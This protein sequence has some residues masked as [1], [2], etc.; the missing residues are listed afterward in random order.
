[1]YED[2]DFV[3]QVISALSFGGFVHFFLCVSSCHFW[4]LTKLHLPEGKSLLLP[5]LISELDIFTYGF[6]FQMP[7][8]F[9]AVIPSSNSLVPG[10]DAG[11][12]C[13]VLA[14][15]SKWQ[16]YKSL[17]YRLPELFSLLSLMRIPSTVNFGSSWHCQLDPS[18]PCQQQVSVH[19]S[20]LNAV[21]GNSFAVSQFNHLGIGLIFVPSAVLSFSDS[22]VKF[23]FPSK[24]SF[25][26][27][28]CDQSKPSVQLRKM[29]FTKASVWWMTI[30]TAL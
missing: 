14:W 8:H 20:F 23:N 29:L 13:S 5:Y 2:T 1:M 15:P 12:M 10:N 19:M 16:L 7:A 25:R 24:N 6:W 18:L 27:A 11:S 17:L 9:L 4:I 21:T 3:D 26:K 28:D 30:F 22:I